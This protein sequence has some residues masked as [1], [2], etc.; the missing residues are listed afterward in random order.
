MA[1][2]QH[3]YSPIRNPTGKARYYDWLPPHGRTLK[4]G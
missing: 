3:L 2:N 1:A 4:P